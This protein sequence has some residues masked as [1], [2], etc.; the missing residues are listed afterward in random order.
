M[1]EWDLPWGFI[2]QKIKFLS[3]I[4]INIRNKLNEQKIIKVMLQEL[5]ASKQGSDE[6]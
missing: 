5:L 4:I 3:I 6:K 2:K 1:L